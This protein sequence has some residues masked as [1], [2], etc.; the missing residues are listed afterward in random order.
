MSSTQKIELVWEKKKM[1]EKKFEPFSLYKQG[2]Q[3]FQKRTRQVINRLDELF[4]HHVYMCV[5]ISLS[6]DEY[7]LPNV[8]TILTQWEN[9]SLWAHSYKFRLRKLNYNENM[10]S[11][12]SWKWTY[13]GQNT[14][15]QINYHTHL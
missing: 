4:A 8:F 3:N 6:L 9:P 7:N 15:S 13:N 1:T 5:L 14:I 11:F 2:N 10:C 12:R